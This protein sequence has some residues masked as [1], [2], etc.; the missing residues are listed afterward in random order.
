MSTQTSKEFAE[1][2]WAEVKRKTLKPVDAWWTV[3]VLDWITTPL[4]YL[5]LKTRLKVT[6]NQITFVSIF[7]GLG[8]AWYLYQEKWLWGGLLYHLYLIF[9]CLDGR[10][11]R[12]RGTSSKLGA[13]WDGSVNYFVYG[14]CVAAIA[15]SDPTNLPLVTGCLALLVV[16][17]NAVD[18]NGLLERPVEGSWSHFVAPKDSFLTKFRLLPPG[19]FPDKHAILFLIAPVA[20]F[21]TEGV[22][23]NV[24]LEFVLLAAKIRKLVIQLKIEDKQGVDRK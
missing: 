14:L 10:V 18:V 4:V 24:F 11:A 23:L 1:V 19:S 9:D 21:V 3:L 20:G 16:R 17:T 15:A 5:I 2:T 8:S 6:P 12:F 7:I 22:L 13:W